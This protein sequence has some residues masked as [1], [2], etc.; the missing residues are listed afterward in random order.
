MMPP[1]PP[2]KTWTESVIWNFIGPDGVN[3]ENRVIF[4]TSTDNYNNGSLLGTAYQGGL[5]GDGVVFEL[6]KFGN[7]WQE[8]NA[9]NFQ[10]G[11]D[12]R[13]PYAGLVFDNN[14]PANLYGATSD[15]GGGGGGTVFELSPVEDTWTFTPLY[16]FS[17]TLGQSCGP[18]GTLTFDT[19][20]TNLYGTTY[21]DGAHGF[22]N[23]FKL[24]KIGN[25][26]V[27]TDLYDFTGG[28]DGAN[29]VSNVTIGDDGNLYGTASK[30]GSQG[31]GVAWQIKP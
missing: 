22:G 28:N 15:G 19:T 10:N 25:T 27:Y 4:D 23:I 2:S 7:S 20:F 12:G 17:G 18:W 3:P 31:V 29:P 26:W 8:S 11:S 1:V 5:H 6:T 13:Y 9:Y 24:T 21:C 16:S 30:G 14:T